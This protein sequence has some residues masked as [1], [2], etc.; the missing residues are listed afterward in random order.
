MRQEALKSQ[1]L[2]IL[3]SLVSP[4][5]VHRVDSQT[6]RDVCL[7]LSKLVA[8][9]NF[10]REWA[11]KRPDLLATLQEMGAW[12]GTEANRRSAVVVWSGLTRSYEYGNLCFNMVGWPDF[13]DVLNVSYTVPAFGQD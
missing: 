13:A 4:R 5:R 10:S 2:E 11:M 8:D 12:G 6:G 3:V 1:G 9:D 7:A